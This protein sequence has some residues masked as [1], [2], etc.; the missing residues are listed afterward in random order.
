MTNSTYPVKVNAQ[1]DATQPV[2]QA[3]QVAGYAGLIPTSD[4]G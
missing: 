3:L 2:W 4:H 1:L